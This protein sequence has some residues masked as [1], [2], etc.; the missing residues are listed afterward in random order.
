MDNITVV[1]LAGGK[2]VRLK[3]YTAVLPKPLLPI[4]DLPILEIVLRQLRNQGFKNVVLSV[5]HMAR[6]IETFFSDGA[7]LGLNIRYYHE[8]EPLGTAGSIPLINDLS[9]P[10]LVMNGDLLTTLDYAA[11]VRA[12]RNSESIATIAA[13]P[14][15]VAIDFGVLE[16]DERGDLA[17]YTEKPT[18]K[19]VVSMGVNVLSKSAC[20]LISPG[21]YIDMPTLM[22]RLHG[23]EKRV[24]TY[25]QDCEWLDIG[26]RDDYEE[27]IA[28]FEES[29]DKYLGN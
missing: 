5:N 19:F 11:V 1:V 29:R 28:E 22:T 23:A 7:N 20:E 4:G 13:F 24:S 3:P 10:F 2:G 16:L 27:A 12:H 9:D 21:E 15:E 18:L 8:D 14:R 25:Q 26:R 17:K 6:L